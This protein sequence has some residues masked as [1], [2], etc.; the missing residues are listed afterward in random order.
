M[1]RSHPLRA[2][3]RPAHALKPFPIV[4]AGV[5]RG[6]ISIERKDCSMQWTQNYSAVNGSLL[7]TALELDVL[8]GDDAPPLPAEHEEQPLQHVHGGEGSL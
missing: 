2:R 7:L 8:P 4:G 6:H 5:P 3:L 1:R